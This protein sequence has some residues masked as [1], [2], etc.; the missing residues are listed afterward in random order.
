MI[1]E[2]AK[3]LVHTGLRNN[4]P[5]ED[6]HVQRGITDGEMQELMIATVD[7]VYTLLKMVEDKKLSTE[8]IQAFNRSC[9]HWDEPKFNQPFADALLGLFNLLYGGKHA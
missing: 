2:M 9:A 8:H 4:T 7:N 1:K 6:L 3:F 5:L